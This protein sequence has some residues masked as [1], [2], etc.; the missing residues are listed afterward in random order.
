MAIKTSIATPTANSYV[1]VASANTYFNSRANAD[2]WNDISSSTSNTTTVRTTKENLL[3]QA[4][5]EIDKTYRF[6]GSKYN[7]GIRGDSD[8]QALEFPRSHDLLSDSTPYIEDEIKYSTYEQAVWILE[9]QSSRKTEDGAIVKRPFI[10]SETYQYLKPFV[11]RS[12]QATG[13]WPHDGSD[14]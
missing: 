7:T 3:T 2:A 8:Y 14:F 9:R 12:V 10:G 4:T 5:R 13:R 11:L 1:S 6:F